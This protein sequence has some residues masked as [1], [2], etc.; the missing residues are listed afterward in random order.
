MNKSCSNICKISRGSM[1]VWLKLFTAVSLTALALSFSGC[2]KSV[3]N[4]TTEIINRSL[5]DE[6]SDSVSIF[7]YKEN[8]VDYVLTATRME[9]FYDSRKLNAWK[10]RIISYDKFKQVHSTIV[11]DTAYVDEARNIIQARGNVVYSTPNGT[12]KSQIINWDRNIDEIFT[13]E[14]VIL[15]RDGNTLQGTNLRTNSMLSYAEMDSISAEGTV[16]PDEI[17]W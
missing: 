7:Q 11:A 13:P 16:T 2:G 10:V 8:R 9:R 12:I 3:L 14:K 17:D 4:Q 6:T 5:P 1:L 15:I